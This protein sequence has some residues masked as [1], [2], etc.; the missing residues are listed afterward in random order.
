MT[1]RVVWRV[2][3]DQ[4][5]AQVKY[6]EA[7]GWLVR[8]PMVVFVCDLTEGVVLDEL[9]NEDAVQAFPIDRVISIQREV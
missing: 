3:L 8:G 2:D 4:D 1:K 9:T 6:V 7:S 5:F